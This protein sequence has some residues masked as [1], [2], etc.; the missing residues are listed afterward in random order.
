MSAVALRAPLPLLPRLLAGARPDGAAATLDAHHAAYG[1]VPAHRG[2]RLIDLV[3]DSGLTGRGG[4][5]FPTGAKLRAVAARRGTKFVVANGT[6]AEPVSNK[7]KALL[8]RVPHL[9]LD[10]VALAAAAVGARQ[11]IVAVAESAEHEHAAL[12]NALRERVQRRIDRVRIEIAACPGRFVAGEETALLSW[13]GGGAAKPKL[14]PPRPFERGLRGRPTLVQNVET[15]AQLALIARYGPAWFREVGAA[16]DPG[17]ALVTLGGAVGRPGVYECALGTAIGEV[18]SLAGGEAE[19]VQAYL[20]GGFFGRWIAAPVALRTPIAS[21]MGARAIVALPVKRSGIAETAR[22]ARYLAEESAGQ[23]G[24]CVHGLAAIAGAMERL[25]SG[26]AGDLPLLRR[27]LEQVRG[28]G[29]CR[30]PDGAVQLV[31]SALEV[32]VR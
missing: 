4:G 13:L 11:A 2:A 8:R 10:G 26:D 14:V 16:S 20:V 24:P 29:A 18:V 6:E 22:I 7:D 9:V 12:A 15:L 23:C 31:A 30:H 27:W 17:S 1:A 5:A 3:D 25:A 28:R 19:P 21:T 32:F